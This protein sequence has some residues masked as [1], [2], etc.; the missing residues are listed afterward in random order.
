MESL[1][2]EI[3][4]YNFYTRTG[5]I[6]IIAKQEEYLV[7][8]E[9]KYRKNSS[10]GHPLEAVSLQKQRRISKSAL[11]YMKRKGVSEMA[12]RFDVVSIL[13]D[14]IQVVQNAFDFIL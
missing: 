11:Y 13:D 12:V 8:A 3:L 1:G 2:Y 9:V 7:F 10:K 6:D 5:E 14:E 4:E